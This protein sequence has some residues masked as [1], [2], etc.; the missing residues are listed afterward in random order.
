MLNLF[1][2]KPPAELPLVFPAQVTAGGASITLRADGTWE[3]DGA[4]FLE[5][6]KGWRGLPGPSGTGVAAIWLAARAVTQDMERA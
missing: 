6:V 3:G 4:K 5:A 2:R 1:K